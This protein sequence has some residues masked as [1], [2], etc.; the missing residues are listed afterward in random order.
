MIIIIKLDKFIII[1]LFI[2]DKS[3]IGMYA[4]FTDI[5]YYNKVKMIFYCTLISKSVYFCLEIFRTGQSSISE[6]K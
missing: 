6:I 1:L 3:Y 4:I 5:G 2:F